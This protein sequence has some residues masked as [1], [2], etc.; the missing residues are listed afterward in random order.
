MNKQRIGEFEEALEGMQRQDK[1]L[2][3]QLLTLQESI[4]GLKTELKKER[5][6]CEEALEDIS[7]N[8]F[9]EEVFAE[10]HGKNLIQN[11]R[12]E[13]DNENETTED[14][15]QTQGIWKH[16]RQDSGISVK[17]PEAD[18]N[19][20]LTSS[21]S[22]HNTQDFLKSPASI[23]DHK[24]E[25]ISLSKH[26]LSSHVKTSNVEIPQKK[27]SNTKTVIIHHGKQDSGILLDE[28]AV[29]DTKLLSKLVESSPEMFEKMQNRKID[30]IIHNKWMR[31]RENS[32]GNVDSSHQHKRSWSSSDL[33]LKNKSHNDLQYQ[34]STSSLLPNPSH[35]NSCSQRTFTPFTAK[36][37]D[38]SRGLGK[39]PCNDSYLKILPV[40]ARSSS[41]PQTLIDPGSEIRRKQSIKKMNE[42]N[43]DDEKQHVKPSVEIERGFGR[44]EK[45]RSGKYT[46]SSETH[47]KSLIVN[48]RVTPSKALDAPVNSGPST[49]VLKQPFVPKHHHSKSL[50][51]TP[52]SGLSLA[53]NLLSIQQNRRSMES[54]S[55]LKVVPAQQMRPCKRSASYVDVGNSVENNHSSSSQNNDKTGKGASQTDSLNQVN[56]DAGKDISR[57]GSTAQTTPNKARIVHIDNSKSSQDQDNVKTVQTVTILASEVNISNISDKKI[58]SHKYNPEDEETGSHRANVG[59]KRRSTIMNIDTGRILLR[60][61]PGMI[62]QRFLAP[63]NHLRHRTAPEYNVM[64]RRHSMNTFHAPS[65][66][67]DG[68]TRKI[69]EVTKGI[70]RSASQ[71]SLV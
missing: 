9:E 10:V 45:Q 27:T 23:S 26:E 20:I 67:W 58:L 24:P 41:C 13:N 55:D 4:R 46:S 25:L 37:K 65:K 18:S 68:Y 70:V 31:V 66:S 61:Q 28:E 36:G 35:R 21:S 56:E 49:S 60:Q 5:E 40:H 38:F 33:L 43:K 54:I 6:H 52:A 30:R 42:P 64:H 8:E 15:F 3:T 47:R 71:V 2:Y 1:A 7:G 69:P 19:D 63:R 32:L 44:D 59:P 12:E 53:G 51:L 22:K 39:T 62:A 11:S 16:D 48:E 57:Q 14:G 50:P 17:T 29:R 34:H